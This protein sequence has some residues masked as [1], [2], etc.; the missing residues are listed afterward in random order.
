ME[1]LLII[2]SK[3]FFWNIRA[4]KKLVLSLNGSARFYSTMLPMIRG[5]L[6]LLCETFGWFELTFYEMVYLVQLLCLV[7]VVALYGLFI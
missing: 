4:Y 2:Y 7:I 5:H 6:N 1:L 3:S